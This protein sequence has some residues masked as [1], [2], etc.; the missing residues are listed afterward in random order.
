MDVTL[1]FLEKNLTTF[2]LFLV[3]TILAVVSSPLPSFPRRL[4]SVLSKFSHKNNF[5]S[6]VKSKAIEFGEKTQ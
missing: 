1:F 5:R 6:G 4:S 3:M 2:F